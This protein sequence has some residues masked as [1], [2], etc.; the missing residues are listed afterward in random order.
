[1]INFF[2]L[3]NYILGMMFLLFDNYKNDY[4]LDT[5]L[6]VWTLHPTLGEMNYT[7]DQTGL[8]KLGS[9][10]CVKFHSTVLSTIVN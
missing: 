3:K 7:N 5:E 8:G 2:P 1:M 10:R 4:V 9:N 6:S